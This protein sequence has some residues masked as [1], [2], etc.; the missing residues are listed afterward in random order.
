MSWRSV[1]I[2]QRSKLS[3]KDNYMLIRGDS[4]N[5]VHLSEIDVLIIDS[6]EVSIT[7]YLMSELISNNIKVIFCDERH[8]PCSELMPYY[9]C[10]NSSKK[11]FN[12]IK[13]DETVKREAWTNIVKQKIINQAGLLEKFDKPEFKML[14]GYANEIEE[15]DVTNREGHAAKVYFNALFG[16]DF[17]RDLNNNINI[18]LN[19]GYS[20]IL[21]NF[22]KEIAK[23][24]YLTQLGIWHK[25][26]FNPYNLSC[27]LME[28][29]RIIVDECVYNNQDRIFDLDYRIVL[30]D[31]LNKQIKLG[32]QQY[33]L[34]NAIGI[35]AKSVFD[36]I[37][38]MNADE[39]LNYKFE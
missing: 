22:S 18:G 16:K 39:I 11:M 4:L 12:Q 15:Y 1:L 32:K 5:T 26:E 20:I 30:V 13:W 29:F 36:A 27:D 25:N 33:F 21:S 23:S 31:L 37:E 2:T 3:Y 9:G 10:H 17:S 8:M 6:T 19:Y 14:K 34:S 38:D 24:G 28:P 35:Y 7:S